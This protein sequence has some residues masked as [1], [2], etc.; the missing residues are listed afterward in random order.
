M[1]STRNETSCLAVFPLKIFTNFKVVAERL[2]S[3]V[4]KYLMDK[5]GVKD[6]TEDEVMW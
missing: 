3:T 1:E 6:S 4:L 5:I 2:N